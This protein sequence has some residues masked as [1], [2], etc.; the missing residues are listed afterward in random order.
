PSL[1]LTQEVSF[2]LETRTIVR[3]KRTTVLISLPKSQ[4][5]RTK[6][7][8]NLLVSLRDRR[9][10]RFRFSSATGA[11]YKQQPLTCKALF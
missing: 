8:R 1:L 2:S 10:D 5:Q 6:P 9:F 7:R 4:C 11:V 3:K